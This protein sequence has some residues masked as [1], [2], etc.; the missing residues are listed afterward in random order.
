MKVVPILALSAL[1]LSGCGGSSS[2]TDNTENTV[3]LPEDSGDTGTN[4]G[5]DNN[6]GGD[7]G[8]TDPDPGPGDTFAEQMLYAV[9]QVRSESQNC[10]GEIMPA[11]D[12]LEWDLDLQDAAYRHSSDMAN[13][14]FM[15]HTGS[16]NSSPEDRIN[17]TGY[18]WS[19]WAENVAAGQKDI[20]AVMTSWM[21]S[22]GHCKNI[23]NGSVTEM[24]ASFVENSDASYGIYW[25][26]VFAKPR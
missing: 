19:T 9:N 24:G 11:V 8:N 5:D 17:A 7:E 1:L 12:A 16:D 15:S 22:S 2:G 20:D 18:S 21:N 14:N 10:G 6:T 13:N 23:M 3:Q 25:T 4:P 26:Q